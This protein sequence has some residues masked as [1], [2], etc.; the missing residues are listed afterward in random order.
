MTSS[1][2]PRWHHPPAGP[3]SL[4]GDRSLPSAACQEQLVLGEVG[5]TRIYFRGFLEAGG[6]LPLLRLWRDGEIL[7][8]ETLGAILR[9][10]GLWQCGRV[11]TWVSLG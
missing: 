9:A 2:P 1:N 11:P 10:A 6:A 8:L 7:V 3:G 4:G 5:C